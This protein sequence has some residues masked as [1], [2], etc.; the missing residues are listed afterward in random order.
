MIKVVYIYN[1][2]EGVNPKEFEAGIELVEAARGKTYGDEHK[3][4][5][6]SLFKDFERL[7]FKSWLE[8]CDVLRKVPRT[9]LPAL[10]E[11]W[12][13]RR[14]LPGL[15]FAQDGSRSVC[16]GCH[17]GVRYWLAIK[18]DGHAITHAVARCRCLA[19]D[20]W[21]GFPTM[22]HVTKRDD[23]AGWIEN[24]I[25]EEAVRRAQLKLVKAN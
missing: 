7:T 4:L 14:Q 8:V 1:L 13:V 11:Y 17:E 20:R 23:F 19:G 25:P 5:L 2:N 16:G 22:D 3:D 12:E 24:E 10:G 9:W 15:K 21:T 6:K 18:D